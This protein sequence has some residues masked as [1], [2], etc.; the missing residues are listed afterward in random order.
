MSIKDELFYSPKNAYDRM[1]EAELAEC[2]AYA[3]DYK[4]YLTAAKTER[5]AVSEAIKLAEAK[6]FKPFEFGK[7]YAPGDKV[8]D[9]NRGKALT[10]AVIGKKPMSEGMNI[11]GAHVDAPRIDLK[12]MPLY[13]DSQMAFFK[14][15]YY[16]GIRKYQWVTIPLELHG[17]V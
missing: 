17:I 6:G 11:A 3:E 13:E 10:L 2:H 5:L 4:K 7:T 16:G 9:N 1:S 15:H 14:T 12:Q 8:Y